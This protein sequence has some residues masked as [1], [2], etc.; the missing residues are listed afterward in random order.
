MKHEIFLLHDA[1]NAREMLCRSVQ[2]ALSWPEVR[3]NMFLTC[4]NFLVSSDVPPQSW[5]LVDPPSTLP[6]HP[7]LNCQRIER[8]NGEAK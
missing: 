7:N 2:N 6:E 8:G 5:I 3:K 1:F 4:F